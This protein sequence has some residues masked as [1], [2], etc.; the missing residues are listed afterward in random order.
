MSEMTEYAPFTL[1][2]VT[3]TASKSCLSLS[4]SGF[5]TISLLKSSAKTFNKT[6]ESLPVR[7]CLLF[8]S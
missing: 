3:V 7:K 5:A 4:L 1:P 2:I 6:S 8:N